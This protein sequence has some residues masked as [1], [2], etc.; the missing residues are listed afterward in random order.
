MGSSAEK[1]QV[2]AEGRNT[3]RG[4]HAPT[5][6]GSRARAP[7]AGARG[8]GGVNAEAAPPQPPLPGRGGGA[9]V[10][11]W[12]LAES[13]SDPRGPSGGGGPGRRGQVRDHELV[14]EAPRQGRCSPGRDAPC[15]ASPAPLAALPPG[16]C[17]QTRVRLAPVPGSPEWP[18]PVRR[19]GLHLSAGLTGRWGPGPASDSFP[20]PWCSQEPV[21]SSPG[22]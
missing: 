15:P 22:G 16:P 19:R 21:P 6:R 4:P 3:P 1:S 5:T 9:R 7:L 8:G 12:R 14:S 2:S 17:A 13:G 11:S 18:C 10:T 20:D